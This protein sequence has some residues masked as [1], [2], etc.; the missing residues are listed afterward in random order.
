M[1]DPVTII[2]NIGSWVVL[3]FFVGLA[4]IMFIYAGILFAT[5]AGDPSKITRARQAVLIALVGV[6][7]GVAAKALVGFIGYVLGVPVTF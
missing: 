1:N 3:P 6:F 5:S 2:R 4:T 7:I